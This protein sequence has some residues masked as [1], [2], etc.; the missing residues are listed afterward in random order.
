MDDGR[1]TGVG[2]HDELMQN[3][4]EYQEIFNSQISGKESN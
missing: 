4:I 1:I 2:T 3:N